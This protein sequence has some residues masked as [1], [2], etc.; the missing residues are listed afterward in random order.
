MDYFGLF[1]LAF[2]MALAIAAGIGGGEI[3]VPVIKI[4]FLFVQDEAS[5]MSQYCIFLACLTR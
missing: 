4:M 5:T 3:I 2:L 1:T